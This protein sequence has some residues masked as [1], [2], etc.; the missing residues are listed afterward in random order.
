MGTKRQSFIL[1]AGRGQ[2]SDLPQL[3]VLACVGLVGFFNMGEL[4]VKGLRLSY[5]TWSRKIFHQGNKL[6]MV[7]S[8]V[9]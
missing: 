1:L 3:D 4:K 6:V 7:S 2:R 5:F 8:V 9:I